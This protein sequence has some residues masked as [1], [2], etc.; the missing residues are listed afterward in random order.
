MMLL[1]GDVGGTKTA[2]A[3]F[4][5]EQGPRRPLVE[6]TFPSQ[7][8]K[9]LQ[10][11]VYDFL[12]Q[13]NVEVT[14]ASFGVA[15]PVV[16]GHVTATNLPWTM[17]ETELQR[18]LNLEAVSLLNDLNAIAHAVPRLEPD[19]LY[20]LNQGEAV[21]Y[22]PLAVVAPGTGLGEAYLT[23]DGSRY[24]P[25]PSE[26]GHASFAPADPTEVELLRY[27]MREHHHVSAERVCSGMGIP[28]IYAFFKDSGY[29]E[30]PDWLAEQL[31]SREDPTPLIV[32]TG[33]ADKNA[34]CRATV[35]TFVSIL[36]AE[37]GNL[38]LKVLATG[39]VYLGGGIPPRIL[40]ALEHGAFM[41]SFVNKG[42][43]RQL[44][45]GVPVHVILNPRTALLGA[46]YHGLEASS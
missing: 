26:G 32:N 46:A 45:T 6:A 36:G 37:A 7:D 15:G 9:S 19:D 28:N 30:E 33:L 39:G 17:N 2:L 3:V 40:S 1:A 23:W 24:V 25:Q 10:T 29:A 43:F 35:D 22:G 27:L 31:A 38:T 42:R 34:L 21:P 13:V 11:L 14:H 20:T 44:L 18:T 12:A 16:E 8:Y 5:A 4:S 41:E